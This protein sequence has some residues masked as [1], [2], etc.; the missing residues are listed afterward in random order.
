MTNQTDICILPK[1]FRLLLMRYSNGRNFPGD[2]MGNMFN[3][4]RLRE[5]D[6]NHGK[7]AQRIGHVHGNRIPAGALHPK[8]LLKNLLPDCKNMKKPLAIT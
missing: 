3:A 7:G 5:V 6:D 4:E 8:F 1:Y 2:E